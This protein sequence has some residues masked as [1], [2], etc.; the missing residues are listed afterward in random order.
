MVGNPADLL[1]FCPRNKL[2]SFITPSGYCPVCSF[3]H[4]REP[5]SLSTGNC[6]EDDEKGS[7]LSHKKLKSMHIYS[8]LKVHESICHEK[9]HLWISKNVCTKIHLIFNTISHELFVVAHIYGIYG[10]DKCFQVMVMGIEEETTL[11]SQSQ[12]V[13]VK[14]K[15][16]T[17]RT[18]AENCRER[19]WR[20]QSHPRGQESHDPG[21]QV[22]SNRMALRRQRAE[23]LILH[24]WRAAG[25]R[26]T[27]F[28]PT[29]SPDVTSIT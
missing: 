9:E 14:A 18:C 6:G 8:L 4:F 26:S 17:P 28:H 3:R 5:E 24:V 7:F 23:A 13:A 15:V 10:C 1:H 19:I 21:G 22:C 25:L 29:Y 27:A 16:D 2:L 11:F 12:M 20:A